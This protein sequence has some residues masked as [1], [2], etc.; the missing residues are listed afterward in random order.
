MIKRVLSLLMTVIMIVSCPAAVPARET[1]GPS[2]QIEKNTYPLHFFTTESALEN[3]F[4]LYFVDGAKD[5]PFTDLKDWT[6]LVN[7]LSVSEDTPYVTMSV[8]NEGDQVTLLRDNGSSLVCDFSKGTLLFDDYLAFQQNT[9]K[10]YIDIAS[11]TVDKMLE[12]ETYLRAT[13][14]RLRRGSELLVNLKKYD[15][16]MIMQ[17]GKYLLP[18]QTISSLSFTESSV[19]VYFNQES[20][21]F[22]HITNINDPDT[23]LLNALFNED[24][25]TTELRREAEENS[26]TFREELEY[27]IEA[28]SKTEEGKAAIEEIRSQQTPSLSDICLSGPKGPRSDA[29][30]KYGYAELCMELDLNYGLK[31]AHHIDSFGE[32]FAQTGLTEKLLNPDPS[33]AD[34][35]IGELTEYWLD[36][37]H[38]AYIARS[39]LSEGSKTNAWEPG[40]STVSDSAKGRQLA[41]IRQEYPDSTK[42]YYEVGDTAYVTFDKFISG[43]AENPDPDY[44]ALAQEDELPDDTMGQIIL[45]HR[46][47]TREN[48]PIKNVVLDL[49]AN[50]GGDANAAVFVLCWFLGDAPSSISYMATGSESTM[51]YQA[52]VN[53]DHEFNEEDTISDLNL[54]CL[55]SSQS[56]SC[57]NLVPWA[58]KEDGRVTLLGKTS[59]GGSCVVRPLTTAWG[60][61][62][63]ISGSSQISFVKNGAY[64]DVD[65]GVE[66]DFTIMDYNHF[67]DRE[68]LTKYIS[69]LF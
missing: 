49:S 68:A 27:I 29:L 26:E 62:F 14:N 42:P 8:N 4:P 10:L 43:T 40:Y 64:Y 57:A 9:N 45:A 22:T 5:L 19:G 7:V 33:V 56:F 60:T 28:I 37:L 65:Q 6:D 34:S 18:L 17:D 1:E 30:T 35:A 54:F 15:I 39:Y 44:Y 2:H 36:D 11:I 38:S 32:F 59:G 51:S 13:D 53:L 25:L 48:S 20:L 21:N 58:F 47:I 61:S 46:Q 55:I 23:A 67:Y 52:D 16:P 31:S 63:K 24:L 41:K 12:G 50:S 3:G 66:P 69:E